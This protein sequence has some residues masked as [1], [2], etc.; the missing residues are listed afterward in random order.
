MA[1]HALDDIDDAVEATKR[2]LLPVDRARWLGLAVLMF[3]VTG[4]GMSVQFPAF[5]GG[6][7]D[8]D[9]GTGDG[10]DPG[11]PGTGVPDL[12]PEITPTLVA[13]IVGLVALFAVV[14]LGYLYLSAV[15][16]FVF[17]G[18]LRR[19]T[20]ELGAYTRPNLGRGLRLFAFRLVVLLVTGA[21]VVGV[22]L[23]LGAAAGGWP[24]TEWGTAAVVTAVLVGA[25]LALVAALLVGN[26]LGFTTVFVVPIMLAEDR[27]VIGAWRRFWPTLV[28]QWKQYLVYAVVGFLL[29]I[30]IG[31]ATGTIIGIGAVVL[32]IP[33]VLVGLAVIAASGFSGVGA[34]FVVVL[35]VIYLL[36]VLVGSLLVQVPFQT[37]SRYFALLV[38][39][40]TN[41]EFDVIPEARSA[42]RAD[43]GD[44]GT[45]DNGASDDTDTPDD[46]R[47][48]DGANPGPDRK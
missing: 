45:G 7:F 26:L 2:F 3:F 25:V 9:T 29:S 18:S 24:P 6:G 48:S 31:I 10:I 34:V 19:E 33:F 5:P 15:T 8:S 46:T 35:A 30:G 22:P 20:V 4:G 17:V 44:G 27:G 12:T 11:E 16:E 1:L 42:V 32:A 28:G 23:V 40:D 41:D 21:T 36:A 13:L 43:G 14:A 37:F 38:L 39:G 47:T